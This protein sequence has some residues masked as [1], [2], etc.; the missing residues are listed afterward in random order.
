MERF[1]FAMEEMETCVVCCS[2]AAIPAE[3][4]AAGC[5]HRRTICA[6]CVRRH[7]NAELRGKGQVTSIP[8]PMAAG[9]ECGAILEY[10]DVQRQASP[11]DFEFYDRLLTTRSLEAMPEFLWCAA[12]GCGNGQLHFEM[13]ACPIVTCH[14]C[15]G[16][17]CFTHHCVWHAGRTC[18]QYDA[19]ARHSEEV[20]LLQTLERS[21]FKR[22]PRCKQ[23]IEKNAGCDH[24]T[25]RTS[26]GG[27]GHEFCW[28]CLADYAAIRNIGNS[29]H[30]PTCQ[31]YA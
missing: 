4:I 14:A 16:K 11:E 15:R 29:A 24:M 9:G 22:C 26:A 6:P 30:N 2:E 13:H 28:L 31:Y 17:T 27:C 25:C 1:F 10:Q 18:A 23:G 5:T 7:I 19:D 8:C 21:D 12:G 3:P 20:A